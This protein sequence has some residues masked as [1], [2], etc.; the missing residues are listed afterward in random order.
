LRKILHLRPRTISLN[1]FYILPLYKIITLCN[2]SYD[3]AKVAVVF[4][5]KWHMGVEAR[6]KVLLNSARDGVQ[7]SASGLGRSSRRGR[8]NIFLLVP[9]IEPWLHGD[10]DP[11]LSHYTKH[12]ILPAFLHERVKH[13]SLCYKTLIEGT[14]T[15]FA[16]KNFSTREREREIARKTK[17]MY[18]MRKYKFCV[19]SYILLDW[20][21]NFYL[22][23]S[24]Y[25]WKEI[26]IK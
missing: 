19:L 6:V 17:H 7:F 26:H 5:T 22:T 4:S 18:V 1:K 15:E 21:I 9:E 23:S 14:W 13:F 12:A 16:K 3:T 24:I 25:V 11:Q 8:V 10:P 2:L 20:T